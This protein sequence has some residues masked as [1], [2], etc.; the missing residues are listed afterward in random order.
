[1]KIPKR[2]AKL[3]KDAVALA[4]AGRRLTLDERDFVLA[5]F[6]EGAEHMNGLAGA[7]FTPPGLARDFSIEVPETG[8]VLDLCAGIGALSFECEREGREIVCVEL[9]PAYV[10]V[11]RAVLPSAT[12]VNADAFDLAAYADL[13]PF[14]IVIAN[15]PFGTVPVERFKGKYTGGLFEFRLIELASW[16]AKRG[17][18]VLPQMSTPFRYSGQPTYREEEADRCRTF[19]EQTGIVMEM[20]CGIDTSTYRAEWKGVSPVCEIVI[21]DFTETQIRA[22]PIAELEVSA[23]VDLFERGAA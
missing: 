1:M 10:E 7:F 3:H 18:F 4:R 8:R 15:P 23:Q 2:L 11:G 5:N 20:N 21:C 6:H 9:N 14:D 19:R 13:G 12:W 17:V 16:I 22:E